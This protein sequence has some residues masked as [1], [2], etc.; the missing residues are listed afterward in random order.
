MEL[1]RDEKRRALREAIR[2]KRSHRTGEH[3][4]NLARMQERMRR[5]PETALLSMGVDDVDVL[6]NAKHVVQAAKQMVG[7]HK[8]CGPKS[9]TEPQS[10]TVVDEEEAPPE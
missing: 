8:V 7:A 1:S 5:D 6:Q 4:G 2:N 3:A 10:E 9:H